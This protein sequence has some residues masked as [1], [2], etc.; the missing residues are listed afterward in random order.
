MDT[1]YVIGKKT[2]FDQRFTECQNG[3]GYYFNNSFSNWGEVR[4]SLDGQWT[5]LEEM[6]HKF[7]WSDLAIQDVTI[8]THSE[9]KEFLRVNILEWELPDI[10]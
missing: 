5:L 6:E 10:V 8:Y 9:I 3:T 1:I 2:L 4:H 7:L